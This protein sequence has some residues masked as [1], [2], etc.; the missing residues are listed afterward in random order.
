MT[1]LIKVPSENT[2]SVLSNLETETRIFSA[3]GCHLIGMFA[4]TDR[5][6]A[7][8]KWVLDVLD[9]IADPV[10]NG[11]NEA[12]LRG[13][14]DKHDV[15][16]I[17][18]LSRED[19]ALRIIRDINTLPPDAKEEVMVR[20]EGMMAA[21]E[22]ALPREKPVPFKRRCARQEPPKLKILRNESAPRH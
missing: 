6:K 17:P 14:S 3:R 13:S 10:A 22:S 18:P 5:A 7:F 20:I 16:A 1:T 15:Q 12:E 11:E 21:K 8:R 4:R 2:D 19:R 9:A